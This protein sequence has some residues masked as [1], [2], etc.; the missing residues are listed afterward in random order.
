MSATGEYALRF[1]RPR[2]FKLSE[3]PELCI[4]F[5][6]REVASQQRGKKQA[7]AV[8]PVSADAVPEEED[9]FADDTERTSL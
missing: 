1:H 8:E 9:E 4:S 7:R 3:D 6:M 2:T 5:Y